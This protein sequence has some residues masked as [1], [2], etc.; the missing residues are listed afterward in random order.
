VVPVLGGAG[1]L[2]AVLDADSGQPAAFDDVGQRWLGR[3]IDVFRQ[4]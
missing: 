1:E 4:M 2:I 3:I